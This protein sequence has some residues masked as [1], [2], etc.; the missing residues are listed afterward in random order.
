MMAETKSTK[1][2]DMFNVEETMDTV[3]ENNKRNLRASMEFT[4]NSFNAGYQ[5]VRDVQE[6][7]ARFADALM[8]QFSAFHKNYLRSVQAYSE[9]FYRVSEKALKD[10]Q[11]MVEDAV[12][13]TLEMVAPG[14]RRRP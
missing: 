7:Q 2:P 5:M 3:A 4:R 14:G 13:K 8:N 1:K 9:E 10:N 6:E 12:D 11:D